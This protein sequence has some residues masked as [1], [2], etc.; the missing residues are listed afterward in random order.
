MHDLG[1]LGGTNS[2]SL[3]I[4]NN[5]QIVG[6]S[7]LNGDTSIHAFLWTAMVGMQDLNSLIPPNSGWELSWSAA[8]NDSGQIVGNGIINGQ[9]HGFLLTPATLHRRVVPALP[10]P[11]S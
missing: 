4:N 5:G 2:L 8:I 9:T 11:R 6:S 7:A 1:T 10:S 3:G